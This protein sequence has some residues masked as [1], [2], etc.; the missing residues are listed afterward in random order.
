MVEGIDTRENSQEIDWLMEGERKTEKERWWR[1]GSIQEYKNRIVK[2]GNS[3]SQR[4]LDGWWSTRK[5]YRESDGL[6]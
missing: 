1:G 2:D 6:R 5:K 3:K 4:R